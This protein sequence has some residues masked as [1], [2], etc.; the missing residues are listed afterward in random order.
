MRTVQQIMNEQVMEAARAGR[1]GCGKVND[2][3]SL[4]AGV[5][6]TDA[7]FLVAVP[8]GYRIIVPCFYMHLES[9]SD[10][11]AVEFGFTANADGSGDFTAVTPEFH[12]ATSA[13]VTDQYPVMMSLPI[14]ICQAYAV[15]YKAFTAKVTTNDAGAAITI[16]YNYILETT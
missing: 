4:N 10:S 2:K 14:P 15:G 12:I 7:G 8:S 16:A 9:V 13:A 11:A 1:A 5:V 3:A 6:L